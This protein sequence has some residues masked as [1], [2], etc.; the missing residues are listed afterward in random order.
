MSDTIA[1]RM[2]GMWPGVRRVWSVPSRLRLPIALV[3]AVVVAEAAVLLLR[4]RDR[5]P[6]PVVVSPREYFSE[7]QIRR[8]ERFRSGQLILFG[9]STAVE[10]GLLVL[11]VRR[12]PAVMRRRPRRPILAGAATAAALSLATGLVTLPVSAIARERA[13]DVGLVT[14]SWIGWAGD[15][16]KSRAIGTALAA[17]GGALLIV[18]MRRFGR[19]WW[20]PGAAV[21]TVF[22]VVITY[23]GPIVLD[24]VF[25][26][27]TPLK[28]GQLRTDVVELARRAGVEVGQV[29]V[30]DASR[31]TTAANAYVAGLGRTKRVVLYDNLTKNFKPA[32]T[33]LIV[34]HELGHV[35]H[36]DVPH[37]LLWL[38]IVAPAG[39]F[40]AARLGEVLTG[41]D[42]TAP[43]AVAGMVLALAIVVPV[44]TIVSNQL[45]R[46]VERRADAYSLTLTRDPQTLIEMQRRLAITNVADPDPPALQAALLGTHPPTVER[47]G[48]ALGFERP[49]SSGRAAAGAR[50]PAAP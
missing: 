39:M 19:R 24:P 37:G 13:K 31:R 26:K 44:L 33:R 3:T 20:L 32:E 49:L 29:Y 9:V 43:R 36:R 40:A 41:D 11:V 5:L 15:V 16:A 25:N 12:P 48:T 14:Q 7:A 22:G 17:G 50:S 27:F 30:V 18:G 1:T 23:A 34:A 35:H 8:A 2:D 42:D 47:I 6:T 45:S 38:A 28:A 10:L 46:A 21:V 4:P